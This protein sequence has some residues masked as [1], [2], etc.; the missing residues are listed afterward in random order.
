MKKLINDIHKLVFKSV[1]L[2]AKKS[3]KGITEDDVDKLGEAAD[4]LN[5][6]YEVLYDQIFEDS[7]TICKGTPDQL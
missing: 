5:D 4:I 7:E 2:V 6:L 3:F 1:D